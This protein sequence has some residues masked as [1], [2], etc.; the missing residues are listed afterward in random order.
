MVWIHGGAYEIGS[1]STPAYHGDVLARRGAVIV[2]INY[3]LGA[4]GFLSH[5]ELTAELQYGVSGNYGLMDVVAALSWV[6]ENIAAFG[7]DPGRVTIFG[8]FRWRRRRDD[9]DRVAAVEGLVPQS[10]FRKRLV[11]PGAT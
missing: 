1:G 8:E 4:L 5:P 7:G 10:H 2:T 9:D 6:Q 11:D 3:R